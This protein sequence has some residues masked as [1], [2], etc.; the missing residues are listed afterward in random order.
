MPANPLPTTSVDLDTAARTVFGEARGET[1]EGQI[2]VLWVIRNRVLQPCWWGRTVTDVCLK[3]YQF[4]CWLPSD[5]NS[6]KLQ[7]VWELRDLAA[8]VFAGEHPD[9]TGGATHYKVTG[10]KAS[11]DAAVA[12]RGIE[13]VVI[14]HHSFFK[15]G[16]H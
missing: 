9:P 6:K 7:V 10:T 15:I 8:D 2:A 4:S 12:E 1:V 11:W 14:G 13:P 5:P 3:P 16:P